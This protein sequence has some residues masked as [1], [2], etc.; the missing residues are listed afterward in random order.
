VLIIACGLIIVLNS[1]NSDSNWLVTQ[2]TQSPWLV[3]VGAWG[4]FCSIMF[5]WLIGRVFSLASVIW[6]CVLGTVLCFAAHQATLTTLSPHQRHVVIL[7]FAFIIPTLFVNG[8][9]VA[10]IIGWLYRQRWNQPASRAT[11]LLERHTRLTFALLFG[12]SFVASV[13]LSSG[14]RVG[15]RW[16]A[17]ATVEQWG[18]LAVKLVLGTVAF[19]IAGRAIISWRVTT[20][21]IWMLLSVGLIGIAATSNRLQLSTS[22]SLA[23]SS[24]AILLLLVATPGIILRILQSIGGSGGTAGGYC[25]GHS[26]GT[27]SS[28]QTYSSYSSSES[29][30]P[31]SLVDSSS[32]GS[33]SPSYQSTC[34]P[35]YDQN[36]SYFDSQLA[37]GGS[38][39][40]RQGY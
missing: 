40:Q 6:V 26:F 7:M 36:K 22:Q 17:I 9:L 3:V 12:A 2:L 29:W 1:F 21:V 11:S 38:Q 5:V 39:Q 23:S 4:F 25:N 24:F 37:G 34:T 14:A 33:S 27:S 35:T 18:P 28:S 32:Y 10:F 8:M 16:E 20:L 19:F 13:V 30:T 31:S 15:Y